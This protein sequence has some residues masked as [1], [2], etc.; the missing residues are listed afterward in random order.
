MAE[1]TDWPRRDGDRWRQTKIGGLPVER[2][3]QLHGQT[4]QRWSAEAHGEDDCASLLNGGRDD[5]DGH[6]DGLTPRALPGISEQD[7][8][9]GR[10]RLAR[11]SVQDQPVSRAVEHHRVAR[12]PRRPEALDLGPEALFPFP[13]VVPAQFPKRGG[14]HAPEEHEATSVV[15]HRRVEAARRAELGDLRPLRAVP[16]PGVVEDLGQASPRQRARRGRP[17]GR[18]PSCVGDGR[19]DRPLLAGSRRRHPIPRCRPIRWRPLRRTARSVVAHRRR[20]WRDRVAP[21]GRSRRPASTRAPSQT[22]VSARLVAPESSSEEHDP[23]PR[24]VV[25]HRVR[26]AGGRSGLRDLRPEGAIPH[27]GIAQVG[28]A[29]DAAKEHDAL[30]RRVVGHRVAPAGRGAEVEALGPEHWRHESNLAANN[31]GGGAWVELR[32]SRRGAES[33]ENYRRNRKSRGRPGRTSSSSLKHSNVNLG[34]FDNHRMCR[35]PV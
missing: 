27:P 33:R 26:A 4:S 11:A 28:L 1:V 9:V 29:G 30:P 8:G 35:I 19:P 22:Q 18:G 31:G 25:G 7:V 2:G 24:G 21:M 10:P 15:R 16:R 34:D 12:A 20:P 32:Q 17:R 13:A 14:A 6:H 5:R 3:G 23:L